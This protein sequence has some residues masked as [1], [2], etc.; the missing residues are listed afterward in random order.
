MHEPQRDGIGDDTHTDYQ[1]AK[2]AAATGI[3]GGV[4]Q[5]RSPDAVRSGSGSDRPAQ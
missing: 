2:A 1:A 5:D 4:W 3:R